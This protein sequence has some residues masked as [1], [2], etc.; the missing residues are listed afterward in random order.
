M[1]D[2]KFSMPQ[3]LA[4]SGLAASLGAGGGHFGGELG[5]DPKLNDSTINSCMQFSLHARQHERSDCEGE[6]NLIRI[7]CLSNVK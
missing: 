2:T 7:G 6:K 1:E 5:A 3:L 4:A